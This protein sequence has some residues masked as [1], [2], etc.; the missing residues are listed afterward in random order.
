MK[1]YSYAMLTFERLVL[2]DNEILW[3]L[4]MKCLTYI[5]FFE[6][7]DFTLSFDI[8]LIGRVFL[9]SDCCE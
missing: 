9:S 4:Y 5:N 8:G 7:L 2:T 1:S 3:A 6:R